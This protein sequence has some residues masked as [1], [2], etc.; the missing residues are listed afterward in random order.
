MDFVDSSMIVAV[1]T[2]GATQQATAISP[3]LWRKA[4]DL[5]YAGWAFADASVRPWSGAA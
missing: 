4:N 3:A 5:D 1:L 2:S